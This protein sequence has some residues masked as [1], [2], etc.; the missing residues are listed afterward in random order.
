MN[1][2]VISGNLTAD[3]ETRTVNK[4]HLC[5]FTLAHNMGDK[6]TFLPVE[7]WDMDWLPERVGKGGRLLASGYLKQENWETDK[8]EKRSRIVLVARH[9][10]IFSPGTGNETPPPPPQRETSKGNYSRKRY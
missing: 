8:G 2:T 9:A 7:A 4:A 3:I 10:E 5:K 1:Q 6:A